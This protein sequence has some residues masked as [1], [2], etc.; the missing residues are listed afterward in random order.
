MP[1][2]PSSN[3]LS[4][5]SVK[6]WKR[7]VAPFTKPSARRAN[8]QV[9]NS[10]GFY[11][12]LWVVMFFTSA[13]S[14]WLTFAVALLAGAVLVR[15]FI[16]F[17][18]CGHGSYYKSRKANNI[19]G[20]ICGVLTFTPYSHWRWEHSIHH[21][22]AGN[23]DRRGT[24]DVWTMTTDEYRTS[25]RLKRFAYRCVRHPIGLLLVGPLYL[26]LIRE[27]FS[28]KGASKRD[29]RSVLWINLSIFSLAA[30]LIAIYGFLPWLLIQLTTV[31]VCC[32]CGVWLFYVQ[33]QFEDTYWER[34]ADWDYTAAALHGSSF[35]KLPKL[36]QWFS[37]NIGFHHIHHLSSR[38]P[39]YNLEK[40]HNSHELFQEIEPLTFLAS[41][42][43]L[44]FHLWDEDARELISFREFRLRNL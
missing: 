44:R 39:N 37:G 21:G 28:T 27:R 25:P 32:T 33:H 30:V 29:R 9:L 35:Y 13:V 3:D 2:S 18:D 14:L 31:T 17:H 43:T 24:G 19:V 26:F 8:W 41:L 40:C 1:H 5:P 42:R 36:F 23:L 34:T 20:F 10:V 16:I 11:A 4:L 7:I 15:I 12:A 22:A 38:I 6:E